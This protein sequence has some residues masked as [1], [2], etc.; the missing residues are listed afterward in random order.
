MK[1]KG[2]RDKP[3]GRKMRR[4]THYKKALVSIYTWYS[5]SK[6]TCF[7]ERGSALSNSLKCTSGLES[8]A[9]WHPRVPEKGAQC[10]GS[11][12]PM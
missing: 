6:S 9:I 7:P 1:G 10:L 4:V 8:E 12:V 2:A 5:S 3:A 11:G